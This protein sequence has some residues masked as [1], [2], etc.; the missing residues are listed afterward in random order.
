LEK[1]GIK[2]TRNAV[3][4]PIL[5]SEFVLPYPASGIESSV[6]LRVVKRLKKVKSWIKYSFQKVIG[7]RAEEEINPTQMEER[8]DDL[9]C[10]R[11]L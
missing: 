6:A 4:R 8:T 10:A 1:P 7:P 5:T 11:V 3:I 9:A 2:V